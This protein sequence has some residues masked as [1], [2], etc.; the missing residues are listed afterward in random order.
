MDVR[1]GDRDSVSTTNRSRRSGLTIIFNYE[2]LKFLVGS[3]RGPYRAS[4]PIGNVFPICNPVFSAW[5]SV[6]SYS[7]SLLSTGKGYPIFE[8]A[9]DW[10]RSSLHLSRG[11][12]LGDVGFVDRYGQF[13]M[14]FNIF[15]DA[16]D[17]VHRKDTPPGFAP[18]TFPDPTEVTRIPNCFPAGTVV[19]TRGINI[20][21]ISDSPLYVQVFP[22]VD[23]L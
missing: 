23:L 2:I 8:A 20:H 12:S 9:G 17:P 13:I 22:L 3:V 6:E 16:D 1:E 14:M 7:R 4:N 21:R 11:P 5:G 18:T 15:A 10:T 19:A